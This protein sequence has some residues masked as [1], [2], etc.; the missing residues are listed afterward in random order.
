MEFEEAGAFFVKDIV[1][2]CEI[3]AEAFDESLAWQGSEIAESVES[4]EVKDFEI[5]E[6]EVA[7]FDEF[8]QR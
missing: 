3:G 6:G 8:V 1:K 4:P 7:A 2:P 5:F